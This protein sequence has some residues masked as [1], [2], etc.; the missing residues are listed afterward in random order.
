M[1][2]RQRVD[3]LLALLAGYVGILRDLSIEPLESL[4]ADD[5]TRGAAERYLQLALETV[6]VVGNHLVAAL[7]LRQPDDYADV[8][9]VLGESGVLDAEFAR[10]IEPMAGLRNR[11]VH[12]YWEVEA[13]RVHELLQTRLDDFD[14]F[15]RE[16]TQHLDRLE[17]D[18]EGP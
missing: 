9:R 13:D 5:R 15:A 10:A 8:V 12:V 18:G 2:D 11:L 3:Q 6:L 7:G 4:R 16:V 14:R 17:Q 1:V